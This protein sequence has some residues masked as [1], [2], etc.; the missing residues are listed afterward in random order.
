MAKQE[1]YKIFNFGKY[2]LPSALTS[3]FLLNVKRTYNNE[4]YKEVLKAYK[5]NENGFESA[6][7]RLAEIHNSLY[8]TNFNQTSISKR[9]FMN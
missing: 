1:G 5:Y 6:K 7:K 4:I 2:S 8:N 9:N 3:A